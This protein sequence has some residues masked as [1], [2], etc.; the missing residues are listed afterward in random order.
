MAENRTFL[1]KDVTK[2]SL[3]MP[4]KLLFTL[5]ESVNQHLAQLTTPITHSLLFWLKVF[6]FATFYYRDIM[7]SKCVTKKYGHRKDAHIFL[8]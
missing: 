1:L 8:M 3:V 2:S 7:Q 6:K 4:G 5:L